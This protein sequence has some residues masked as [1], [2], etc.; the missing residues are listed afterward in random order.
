MTRTTTRRRLETVFT[1]VVAY[2]WKGKATLFSGCGDF[3]NQAI[4]VARISGECPHQVDD[5]F[6]FRGESYDINMTP[7]R[8]GA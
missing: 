7:I 2:T 1:V 8:E 4:A 5:V 6:V 3:R